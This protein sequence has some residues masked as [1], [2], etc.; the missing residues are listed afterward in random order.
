MRWKGFPNNFVISIAAIL[1]MAVVTLFIYRGILISPAEGQVYPWGSDTLG[2]VYRAEYLREMIE[3]GDFYPDLYPGWYMGIQLLRYHPPLPNYFLIGLT[4]ALGDP[5]AAAN[6]FIAI[7]ALIGGWGWLLYQ[8]WI[9]WIPAIIGGSLYI[10]LPDNVRVALAEGNLPR[11]LATAILPYAVYLL[12]HSLQ[13]SGTRWHRFGL[14][15][16]FALFVLIHAMM[17]AIYA[18]CAIVLA[19]LC[20]IGRSTS[21]R[22]V[23]LA[24]ASVLFGVMLSGLW[25]LP[26]LTGGITD[27]DTST[28]TEAL[29]VFPLSNYLNPLLR[30]GNPEA[31]YISPVLLLL[32]FTALFVG[33]GRNGYNIALTLVGLVGVLITTPG[34]NNLFNAL[35]LH[36]LLWPLRF[37]GIASFMLLFGLMWRM[38]AWYRSQS[39]FLIIVVA[40][41]IVDSLGSLSLIHLRPLR[42]DI[43][44]ISQKLPNL[45]GWREA[46]LDLSQLGSAASLLFSADSRKEQIYGWAYQGARTARNVAGIN[47]AMQSGYTGYVLDRLTLLGADDVVLLNKLPVAREIGDRLNSFGFQPIFAG[48]VLTLHHRDG[49]PRAYVA[50]WQAF[51][52]GRGVQNFAYIFP[53]IITGTSIQVDDYALED[54]AR[55]KTLVLSGF[56]WKDRQTAED[57]IR[58]VAASGVR[59]VVDLT[60]VPED[61]VARIPRFLD[62]WAEQI[63]LAA[64]PIRLTSLE[65][66]YEL[67]P[68]S[69]GAG[70]WYTHTPQGIEKTS[71]VFDYLGERVTALGFNNY[72]AGQVWF[73]GINLP[74]HALISRDPVAISLLAE[75]LQLPFD[76]PTGY[77]V[78]PLNQYVANQNG[79]RFIYRLDKQ[80]RLTFPVAHH[81]GMTLFIDNLPA[82][83]LSIENLVDFDAPKGQHTVEIRIQ[84]TKIHWLGQLV[85]GMA[86]L[87]ISGQF[88]WEKRIWSGNSVH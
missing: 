38:R 31:V 6:W 82:R 45:D 51:G 43:V 49:K 4:L 3:K 56:Q 81:E 85:S 39:L 20:W 73:I 17:A 88:I 18:V 44:T 52:I 33:K 65:G 78:V 28:M 76:E 7:C 48:D 32:S 60:R 16:I 66:F 46:T 35:P 37:L 72:G 47:E 14:T 40:L 87:G 74:Y 30:I 11:A 59:V 79:Y 61:P 69:D 5:I 2:H 23:A 64:E 77:S 29:A 27:L 50:N 22:L 55:Y 42:S 36:N 68:F 57:L 9:G 58:K 80:A 15:I 71:L 54:L 12:L 63:I 21:F 84:P 75:L 19:M 26:S 24:V 67:Q 8:R 13:K 86:L 83:L 25:L 53:Q 10:F 1:L 70:L 41:L 62:V 34:V